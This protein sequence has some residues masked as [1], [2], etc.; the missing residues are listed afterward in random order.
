M[1]LTV[2]RLLMLGLGAALLALIV[3]AFL[4]PPVEVDAGVVERGDMMVT[5]DHEGKTRVKDRYVVSSPLGGRLS[6]IHLRPGDPVDIR[7]TMLAIIEPADPALLDVRTRTQAEAGV[8][9]ARASLKQAKTNL[10]RTRTLHDQALK[11]LIRV[12]GLRQNRVISEA[13]FD[14]LAFKEQTTG[15]EHRSAEFALRIAE[16]ELE[17]AQAALIHTRPRSPGETE[18][19]RFEVAS[20]ITGVVLRVFQES[21]TVVQAGTR[22]LEVG[23]PVD[24]EC[25]IDVLSTDAVKVL[26]GQRVLLEHWGG[27][28]P[29]NGRVRVREPSGFTKISALGVEE[30]RVNIIVDLV[31]LPTKR[32][33]LGDGYRVEARII[34]WEGKDVV[35]VPAGSLFRQGNVWQVFRVEGG[36]V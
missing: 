14:L 22:L 18:P 21:S 4:P 8:E 2:P 30:Q 12:R 33:T 13:D 16:F 5:V 25:E 28:E 15:A 9:A 7:R 31:D 19:F 23:D 11:E 1:K 24:L 10:E 35:K 26:P 36:R 29:L 3:W 20:P 6:R 34:I 32:S 17:Q 27:P